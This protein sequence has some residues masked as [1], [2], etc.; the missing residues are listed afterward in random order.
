MIGAEE[1]A[2][3]KPTAILVNTSRGPLVDE[4]ALVEALKENRI[5]GAAW[6]FT[7]RNPCRPTIHSVHCR[8]VVATPHLGYVTRENCPLFYDEAVEDIHSW[9]SGAQIRTLPAA[10]QPLVRKAQINR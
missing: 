6:I 2:K 3:M 5:A 8:I 9:L 10:Q 4:K 7:T 1:L